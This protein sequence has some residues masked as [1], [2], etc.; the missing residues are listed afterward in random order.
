MHMEIDGIKYEVV[1]QKKNNKN[2]YMR[3]K[4]DLKIYVSTNKRTSNK[5]IEDVLKRNYDSIK[6]MIDNVNN[7]TEENTMFLGR[8]VDIVVVSNQKEPEIYNNKLY[9]KDRSKLDIYYKEM[10]YQIFKERLD[11][12]YNIFTE[13]IPYPEL[14][15]RKMTSRWGV[16]NRKNSSITINVELVKKDLIY[17]DYVIVHELCH[18]IHFNHSKSF[19]ISVEKYC[20]NYKIIRKQMR[21][22]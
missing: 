19:W 4:K 9:I 6:K 10:A 21:E 15:L 13:D 11:I 16:C 20:K 1:I 17:V 12:I 18:F 5:Y 22:W 8:E 7:K 3:V 2:I 14:K